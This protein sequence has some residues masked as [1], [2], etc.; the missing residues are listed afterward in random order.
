[1]VQ[2]ESSV[3]KDFSLR[4]DRPEVDRRSYNDPISRKELRIDMRAR[5]ISSS[6]THSPVLVQLLQP[7]HG[8]T[9]MLE[10]EIRSISAPFSAAPARDSLTRVSAFPPRVGLQTIPR[11][12]IKITSII[13]K[14]D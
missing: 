7:S 6:M 4:G 1:M 10:K 12:F 13:G 5:F 14:Q 3:H 11:T 2:R 9:L 8:L